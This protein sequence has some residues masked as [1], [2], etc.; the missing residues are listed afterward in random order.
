MRPGSSR[1]YWLTSE[2]SGLAAARS[3]SSF[4]SVPVCT[5]SRMAPLMP[6]NAGVCGNVRIMA[7]AFVNALG[8]RT[9]LGG[10]TPRYAFTLYGFSF[11]ADSSCARLLSEFGHFIHLKE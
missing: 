7:D 1:E 9:D 2:S 8:Q 10:G 5:I 4:A 6:S 11:C 3:F